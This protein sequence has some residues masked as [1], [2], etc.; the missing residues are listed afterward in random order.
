MS[1]NKESRKQELDITNALI[2]KLQQSNRE[3]QSDLTSTLL[4]DDQLIK[5]ELQKNDMNYNEGNLTSL[6]DWKTFLHIWYTY[7][8]R[9]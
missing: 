1:I 3:S 2:E 9:W 6:I 4:T 7:Y 5:D 8:I